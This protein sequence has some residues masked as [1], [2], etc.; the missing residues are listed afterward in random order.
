MLTWIR[1][2]GVREAGK[3]VTGLG[4][5]PERSYSTAIYATNVAGAWIDESYSVPPPRLHHISGG[6]G[7]VKMVK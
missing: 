2:D 6:R 3:G 1:D 4:E 5:S 7:S